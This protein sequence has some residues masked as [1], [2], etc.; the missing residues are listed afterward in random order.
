MLLKIK[1]HN[2]I[3]APARSDRRNKARYLLASL[4]IIGCSAHA[5]W[6]VIEKTDAM[7]DEKK[8]SA[9]VINAQ[10]HAFS[11]YRRLP[12]GE[13]WANFSLSEQS[14]DQLSPDKP[15]V[16]RIDKNPP[17]EVSH[18]SDRTLAEMG[19]RISQ[20]CSALMRLVRTDL[21]DVLML[22]KRR[23]GIHYLRL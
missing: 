20:R 21:S 1:S 22:H 9:K 14:A 12:N 23:K 5:D 10:G 17:I 8:L 6:K 7:T 2:N 18:S 19:I 4:F 11:V 15:L 13:V 3:P 16:Y